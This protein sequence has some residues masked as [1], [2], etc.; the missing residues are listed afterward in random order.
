ML[1]VFGVF[2]KQKLAG[3]PFTVVGDGT[4][5]RDFIYASDVARAFLMAAESQISGEVFNL[6][7]NDP[8]SVN[9]LVEL[10]GGDIVYVPKRPGEPDCTWADTSHI[11]QKLNWSPE[12]EF[13][14]GVGLM[15]AEIQRWQEAPLWDPSSIEEA[16][17]DWFKYLGGDT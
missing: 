5:S 2:L 10:L 14:K 1:K 8:Q 11:R 13:E 3:Q 4:Q 16:T 7:A 9:R 12:I 15:M 17:K 6:G